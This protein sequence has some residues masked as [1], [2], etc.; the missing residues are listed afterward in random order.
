MLPSQT[1]ALSP[2]VPVPL[3]TTHVLHGGHTTRG[4]IAGFGTQWLWGR[5]LASHVTGCAAWGSIS[6]LPCKGDN[7]GTCFNGVDR[8]KGA[9]GKQSSVPDVNTQ[10]IGAIPFTPLPKCQLSAGYHIR[11]LFPPG[12]FQMK[13]PASLRPTSWVF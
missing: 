2:R 3:N 9:E 4:Y 8:I 1:A 12:I 7:P 10:L 5:V 6:C 13:G 11:L